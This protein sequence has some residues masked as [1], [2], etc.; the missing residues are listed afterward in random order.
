MNILHFSL[1]LPPYRS[2]GLTKYATDLI[3]AQQA[4]GYNVSLL[5]PG[6]FTFWKSAKMYID[7]A[8]DFNGVQT[9]EI[10]NPSLV[11]LLHGVRNPSDVYNYPS[12]EESIMLN[13]YE[14]LKPDIFHVHTLMGMPSSLLEY[15]KKNG[16]KIIFTTHDYFGLCAKANFINQDNVLCKGAEPQLCA[17]CNNNAESTL[18]LKLRNSKYILRYKNALNPKIKQKKRQKVLQTNHTHFEEERINKYE[19]LLNYYINIFNRFDT[20]HFNSRVTEQVYRQY[21]QIDHSMVIP[22]SHSGI[23]DNRQLKTFDKNKIRLTFIGS[24]DIYKG[25]SELK[26]ALINLLREGVRNWELNVFGGAVA[27]DPDSNKINYKGRYKDEEL[28]SIFSAT[29]MLI[30]PS[31]WKETFS[32]ITLEA[33]SFAVP[34]LVTESVGAKDI[35]KKYM[36]DFV[37]PTGK[38]AL[39]TKLKKVLAADDD[40]LLKFNQSIFT[41]DF[42]YGMD[43]HLK[44]I[45]DLYKE[46]I[47]S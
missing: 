9:F 31:V 43:E 44:R 46:A 8:V 26:E 24:T 42:R 41:S 40:S 30:V 16:V 34:V 4:A 1:G 5:Y 32:F 28:I 2:G 6:D 38:E 7:G 10:K 37:I 14:K 45:D 25:F 3:V 20:I 15:F 18:F 17:L 27:T 12:L 33:L 39:F 11:P 22:I 36:P 29:D 35:V 21:L 23:S 19:K 13:F 47:K